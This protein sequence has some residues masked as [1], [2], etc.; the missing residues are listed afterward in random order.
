ML[1]IFKEIFMK[2]IMISPYFPPDKSVASIRMG[3]LYK[4]LVS[5]GH[6]VY[7]ITNYK[8]IDDM[9]HVSFVREKQSNSVLNKLSSFRE[10]RL[11]YYNVLSEV[12]K[13]LTVISY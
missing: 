8:N 11:S 1:I 4:Y 2:I 12:M 7:V 3:S 5:K 9:E 10:N 13:N 6:T